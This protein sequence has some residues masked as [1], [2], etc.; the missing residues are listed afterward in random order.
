VSTSSIAGGSILA[1]NHPHVLIDAAAQSVGGATYSP[2]EAVWPWGFGCLLDWL[3]HDS[4][5]VAEHEIDLVTRFQPKKV[6]HPL[7]DGDLTF[8]G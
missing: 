1:A 3:H 2:V 8:D 5:V 6:S 4:S 7:G